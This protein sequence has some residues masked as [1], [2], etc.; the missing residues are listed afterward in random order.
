EVPRVELETEGGP[1]GGFEQL[2]RLGDRRD[3]RPVLTAD[4]VD[5]LEPD[6][7]ACSLGLGTDRAEALDDHL[8]CSVRI[9]GLSRAGQ[10][11]DAA[12]PD[13][14]KPV[15]RRADGLD[16][17]LPLVGAPHERQRAD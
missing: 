7:Y 6:A 12:R 8:P 3:D 13:G 4:T 16:P 9:P 5:R 17:L 11:D 14:R 10:A 1:V 15:E 2:D